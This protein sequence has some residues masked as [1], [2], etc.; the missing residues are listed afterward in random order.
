MIAMDPQG[1]IAALRSLLEPDPRLVAA[2]L[3]GS[4]ATGLAGPRSDVDIAYLAL[5]ATSSES[6]RRERLELTGRIRIALEREVQLVEI[7]RVDTSLRMQ[8]WRDGLLI[9]ERDPERTH[10]LVG[11]TLMEWFDWEYARRQHEAVLDGRFG[12]KRG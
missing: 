11:R 5:D 3:F 12:V 4:V 2:W 9:F 1:V 10:R 6:L 8:V 7:E